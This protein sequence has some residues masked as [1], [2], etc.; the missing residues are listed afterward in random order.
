MARPRCQGHNSLQLQHMC[1]GNGT[2]AI[3]SFFRQKSAA[4]PAMLMMSQ[5]EGRETRS[6]PFKLLRVL[7]L[8]HSHDLRQHLVGI[9]DAI[10]VKCL[11]HLD[12]QINHWLRFGVPAQC[13][14]RQNQCL[15]VSNADNKFS[16]PLICL[17]S[18]SA[19]RFSDTSLQQS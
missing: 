7:L 13:K 16:P 2:F 19:L 3:Y 8:C 11:L 9:E 12:H 1:A 18:T 4:K 5:S 15:G 6:G 10:G 14:S 17:R